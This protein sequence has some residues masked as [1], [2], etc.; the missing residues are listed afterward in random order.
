MGK[1]F[2]SGSFLLW[3]WKIKTRSSLVPVRTKAH[4]TRKLFLLSV[5]SDNFKPWTYLY[6]QSTPPSAKDRGYFTFQANNF[7][8]ISFTV[9]FYQVK[10]LVYWRLWCRRWCVLKVGKTLSSFGN[11]KK[12]PPRRQLLVAAHRDGDEFKTPHHRIQNWITIMIKSFKL[13]YFI[14]ISHKTQI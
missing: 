2:P 9:G 7:V 14:F 12:I 11:G 1:K 10:S 13:N 3:H 5:P 4:G 6:C 8:C